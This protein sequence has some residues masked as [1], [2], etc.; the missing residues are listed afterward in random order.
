MAHFLYLVE[1]GGG[2]TA[3]L[4]QRC[5]LRDRLPD[6]MAQSPWKGEL[7]GRPVAGVLCWGSDMDQRHAAVDEAAQEWASYVLNDTR[8]HVGMWRDRRPHEGDLRRSRTLESDAVQLGDGGWWLVPRL[9]SREGKACLPRAYALDERGEVSSQ[10]AREYRTLERLGERLARQWEVEQ[11]LH[12]RALDPLSAEY[13]REVSAAMKGEALTVADQVL[14]AAEALSANYR[15]GPAE[16]GL[17]G[18]LTEQTLPDVLAAMLCRLQ[19]FQLLQMME[20]EKKIRDAAQRAALVA[21]V[22]GGLAGVAGAYAG[23][24]VAG[25]GS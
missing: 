13:G 4:A 20:V 18:L 15:V 23:R 8:V 7:G 2:V 24:G 11:E 10:V 6:G 9:R 3:S 21:D 19:L 5:G 1:T 17:L 16:V 25:A 22:E 14:L 12:G